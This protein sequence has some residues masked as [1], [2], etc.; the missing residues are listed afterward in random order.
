[1]A[2][3]ERLRAASR[4][5]L[6]LRR[7]RAAREDRSRGARARR[8]DACADAMAARRRLDDGHDHAARRW[9]WHAAAPRA[10]GPR[11]R[12]AAQVRRRLGREV[13]RPRGRFGGG[14]VKTIHHVI[15]MDTPTSG[16]WS[17]LTEERGLAGW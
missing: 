13:R 16:I 14:S 4:V 15:D 6:P 5:P 2:D 3:A 12:V 9:R 1:M 10:R 17:A 11:R 7:G 8:A